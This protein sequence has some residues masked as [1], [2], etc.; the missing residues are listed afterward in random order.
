VVAAAVG[1]VAAEVKDEGEHEETTA[2]DPDP[3]DEPADELV[4]EPV[5]PET[6]EEEAEEKTNGHAIDEEFES[7][8]EEEEVKDAAPEETPAVE[9]KANGNDLED[10]VNML[11]FK[12]VSANTAAI[13]DIPD[14]E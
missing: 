3:V 12:P 5:V 6:P 14:E 8:V 1:A 10:L 7:K 9:A 2:A 11:E 13:S 4:D